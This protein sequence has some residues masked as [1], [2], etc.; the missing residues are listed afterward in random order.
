MGW[1]SIEQYKNHPLWNNIPESSYFY[2][3]HSYYVKCNDE[4]LI[5]GKT[6]YGFNFTSVIANENVFAMQ[7]HPEKSANPGLQLLS[8]FINWDGSYSL[9]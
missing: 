6:E 3:V 7:C 2:F 9:N 8:N 4:S 1:N 5:V